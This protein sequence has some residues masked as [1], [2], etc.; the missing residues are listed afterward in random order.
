MRKAACPT[1][2]AA[3]IAY[4]QRRGENVRDVELLHCETDGHWAVGEVTS[5][6]DGAR[7]NHT[8]FVLKRVEEGGWTF[9]GG[10]GEDQAMP[11][12]GSSGPSAERRATTG[13]R[14]SL[15]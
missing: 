10:G 8:V 2:E 15:P 14:V 1:P 3:I 12:A 4:V 6:S 7:D 13:E 9:Q 11:A 5:I